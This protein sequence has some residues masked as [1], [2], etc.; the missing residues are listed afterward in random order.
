MTNFDDRLARV[1][2]NIKL[3]EKIE[4]RV[5]KIYYKL[6]EN[7]L[8]KDVARNTQFRQ[9]LQKLVWILVTAIVG[10]LVTI[11]FFAQ[12]LLVK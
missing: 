11:L 10:Q 8:T 2:E 9:N 1:E 4:K 7:G 3:L 12:K 5:D 6:Y